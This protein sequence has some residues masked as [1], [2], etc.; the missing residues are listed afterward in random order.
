MTVAMLDIPERP[1][2]LQ[3]AINRKS[4]LTTMFVVRF[5]EVAPGIVVQTPVPVGDDSQ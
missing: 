5:V 4:V 2:K 1:L 3:V